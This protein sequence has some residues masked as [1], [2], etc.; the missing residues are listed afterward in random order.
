MGLLHA[1]SLK[2]PPS[3]DSNTLVPP[4]AVTVGSVAGKLP[5]G[6]WSSPHVNAPVSPLATKCD[7]PSARERSWIDAYTAKDGW[8]RMD[9]AQ[10]RLEAWVANLDEDPAERPLGVVRR[11]YEDAC[12]AMAGGFAK[13]L[14]NANWTAAPSMSQ[15][16]IYTGVVAG[17]PRPVA[18]FLVD[19]M[20]FEMGVE[21]AERLPRAAEVG[22]RHA[23]GVLPS[24]PNGTFRVEFFGNGP[25]SSPNRREARDFLGFGTVTTDANGNA[26][27]S[28]GFPFVICARETRPLGRR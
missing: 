26:P 19:A 18:Y 10:R 27:F 14:V 25:C 12:H 13:A 22:V 1:Y 8:Y 21:L 28:F 11:L 5:A 15:T 17:R 6:S 16:Q 9:Q 20:R 24:S 3:A 4:T 23:V 7:M 2:Y